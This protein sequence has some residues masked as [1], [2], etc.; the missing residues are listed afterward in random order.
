MQIQEQWFDNNGDPAAGYVL[1]AYEVGTTTPVSIAINSSGGSPQATITLNVEGKYEVSG[2]EITPYIDRNYKYAIFENATD[3]AANSNPFAGFYDNIVFTSTTSDIVFS[4]VSQ[5]ALG[6]SVNG[7]VVT[8]VSGVRYSTLGQITVD[9][10]GVS[11]YVVGSETPNGFNIIDLGGG[12]SAELQRGSDIPSVATMKARGYPSGM[13]LHTSG[14]YSRGDGGA[15][16][17]LVK[18]AAEATADGDVIDTYG[19]HTLANTNVAILQ[20]I[21]R[22][23]A[24]QFGANPDAAEATNVLA[25]NAAFVA[26]DNRTVYVP[27]GIYLI[28]AVLTLSGS[29]IGDGQRS[30]LIRQT[31]DSEGIIILESGTDLVTIREIQLNYEFPSNTQTATNLFIALESHSLLV[32]QVFLWGG[33]LGLHSDQVSFTQTYRNLRIQDTTTDSMRIDGDRNDT[34]GAGTTIVI[35]NLAMYGGATGLRA[36]VLANLE[37]G[38]IEIGSHTDHGIN[39]DNVKTCSITN[40]HFEVND[41]SA[42]F[43]KSNIFMFSSQVNVTSLYSQDNTA[44][45]TNYIFRMSADSTL[46]LN[47]INRSNNTNQELYYIDD[48]GGITADRIHYTFAGYGIEDTDT[49]TYVGG[50]TGV[51]SFP[52]YEEYMFT[53]A[54]AGATGV[55]SQNY[56]TNIPG[57]LSLQNANSFI[58]DG[59]TASVTDSDRF[60]SSVSVRVRLIS[61]GGTNTTDGINIRTILRYGHTP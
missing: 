40:P 23:I 26:G 5:M 12:F 7:T 14:Y 48:S 2:N 52:D 4:N 3:A 29:L 13:I 8:P 27:S 56:P 59:A 55:I 19:N 61:T 11:S 44:S 15:A 54:T 45:V 35:V 31:D 20:I 47:G 17:Y 16:S 53:N 10:G 57:E 1:K 28:N 30:T 24:T 25:F 46:R 37:I 9:D 42:G 34:T 6:I 50:S 18:T 36:R 32:D 41:Y 33:N 21:D 60:G 58:D 51:M 39:L 49:G 38:S 22:I 43:A